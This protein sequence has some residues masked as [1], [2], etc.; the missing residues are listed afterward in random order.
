M[1]YKN[2]SKACIKL[3]YKQVNCT[4]NSLSNDKIKIFF[5]HNI[6]VQCSM[7]GSRKHV[8]KKYSFLILINNSVIVNAV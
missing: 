1:K 3:N 2:K 4:A 8:T 7:W 6:H 5:T